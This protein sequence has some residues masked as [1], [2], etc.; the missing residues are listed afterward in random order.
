M[1]CTPKTCTSCWD[2]RM[3]GVWAKSREDVEQK[4][5]KKFNWKIPQYL[6]DF[7]MKRTQGKQNKSYSS[8]LFREN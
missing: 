1:V 2:T 5:I 8:S 7:C 6:A 3:A 4:V